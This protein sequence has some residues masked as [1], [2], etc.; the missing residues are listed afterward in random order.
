M[1]IILASHDLTMSAD[2]VPGLF[3][4]GTEEMV[5]SI[6]ENLIDNA[7]SFAP[8]GSEILVH[9]THDDTFAHLTVSDQ[10]PGVPAAQLERIFDR[11]YVERAAEASNEPVERRFGIGLSIARR[12]VEA[13]GGTI[14]AENRV[15]HGLAVHLRLLLASGAANAG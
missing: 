2:L 10:G 7:V 15:P 5:E 4:L 1:T 9:L 13:M 11:Y 6:A 8:S 12:H 14:E 3:V